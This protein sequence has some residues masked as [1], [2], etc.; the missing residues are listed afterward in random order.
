MQMLQV[1]AAVAL[2]VAHVPANEGV[3]GLLCSLRAAS[4]T[5]SEEEFVSS[6]IFL[7]DRQRLGL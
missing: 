5:T 6:N 1:L 2:K 7:Q 4:I 3:R